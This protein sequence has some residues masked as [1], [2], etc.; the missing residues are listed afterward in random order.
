MTGLRGTAEQQLIFL[1]THWGRMY[2][3]AAPAS[4]GADWVARAKFGELDKLQAESA[5]ELLQEI[6]AH[7][8]ARKFPGR[9]E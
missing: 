4:A 2:E 3:F 5:A 9:D 8:A 7:Y 6:R 1:N